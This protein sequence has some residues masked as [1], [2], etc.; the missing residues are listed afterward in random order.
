MEASRPS[1]SELSTG[2]L[3]YRVA[4][5]VWAVVALGAVGVIWAGAARGRIGRPMVLAVGF[6][7][8]QG[9]GLIVGR[10]NCPMSPVQHRLGDPVPLFELVLPPKAAKA[11]MPVLLVVTLAGLAAAIVRAARG[12]PSVSHA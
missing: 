2:A 9:V 4:H 8:V 10:G 12:A 5:A 3:A 11:A 1:W 6:L 7:L